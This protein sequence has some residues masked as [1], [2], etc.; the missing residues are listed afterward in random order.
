MEASVVAG[1]ET[2]VEIERAARSPLQ[3]R[4]LGP[5]TIGRDGVPVAL[6]AS[7]KVRALVA[8]L[9]LAER[10]V[11][12]PQLCELRWDVPNDPRSEL[13]WCLSKIRGLVDEP[14][15]RRV[16]ASGDVVRLDLSDCVVDAIE[17]ARASERG[18]ATLPPE[19]L[20][21]LLT[22]CGGEFLDGLEMDR[23]PGFNAWLTAQRRRFRGCHVALLE[24]LAATASGDAA[25]EHLETW[26]ELAPF[27]VRA[28]ERLLDAFAQRGRLREGEEHL[29]ATAR[30]FADEGLD[31]TPL[32]ERWRAA[33][34]RAAA[35]V[36]SPPPAP[37]RAGVA[38]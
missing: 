22:L 6:P 7:R 31:C 24:R 32:R 35:A 21:R 29:A 9:V 1:M 27:D 11:S 23:N 38:A 37:E 26:L 3:L 19:R 2:A 13:R 25:V 16:D 28:H 17:I 5:L 14:N 34:A 18:L 33:R 15:R 12:R 10:P 30:L 8:Y 4:L 36:P 20:R